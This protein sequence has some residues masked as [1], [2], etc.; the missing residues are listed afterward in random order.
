MSRLLPRFCFVFLL[1][2]AIARLSFAAD[3]E[4]VE[5]RSP[6]FSVI[7][8]AGEQRGREVALHF[9]QMRAVFA[10]LMNHGAKVNLPIPL[11]IVAFRNSKEMRQFVPL[12]KGKPP[13]MAGLFQGGED[14][15]FIM[16]DM[17]VE[18]PWQVVFHEYAHQLMNGNLSVR[19]DPWFEEGFAEY[20]SSIEVDS[21]EARVG[22]LPAE[23]RQILQQ[24]GWMKIA[25]LF[26][27]QQ[28][29]N[30]YN[31]NG[32]HRTVFYAESG[33]VMHYIYDNQLL[34][35]AGKYFNLTVNDHVP[36]EDAIQQAFGMSAPQL[37]KTLRAYLSSGRYKYYP[38]PTP[39]GIATSGYTSKP[40]PALDTRSV[41]ADMH[42]HSPDY[43][44]KAIVE[45]EDV[46]KAQ[47]ENVAA[48]RGLGYAYLIK[49]DFQRAGEYFS[50]AVEHDS[51]DPRV[52]YYSAL[53]IQRE[54]GFTSLHSDKDLAII[55]KRL[56][57]SITLDPDFADAYSL[58][59]FAYMSEGR[60]DDAIQTMIKAVKLNPRNDGYVF[61]LAQMCLMNRKYDDAISLF[62]Q[63]Q[64]SSNEQVAGQAQR[65]LSTAQEA[66]QAKGAGERVEIRPAAGESEGQSFAGAAE[67]SAPPK[68]EPPPDIR[69]NNPTSPLRFM[70]GKLLSVDCS[71]PPLASLIVASENKTWKLLAKDSTHLVIIGADTFSCDWRNQKVAV[72]YHETGEATGEIISLEL[73]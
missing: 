68:P 61:N 55:E 1:V 16:L 26:R 47:S 67:P 23:E 54:G 65:A 25:D 24:M 8:D 21:K 35:Q 30:V 53:L 71:S 57:K 49:Q 34:P 28:N 18:N 32:D 56:Q 39:A 66:K 51:D 38:I 40:L 48:L 33:L 6:H 9:E 41:L 22:K 2:S 42:L 69:A 64:K 59:A 5:V 45:F 14:R 63:L 31:E 43:R 46:L 60:H 19:A 10:A 70:K 36:V 62:T 72:N 20:F 3:P 73:Q 50:K 44:E 58:L 17:S 29:S 37:D 52:L 12:W 27:V 7:T 4:W 11:Q 13:Q 15:C